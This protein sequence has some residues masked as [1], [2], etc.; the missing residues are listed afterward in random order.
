MSK[1]LTGK[2]NGFFLEKNPHLHMTYGKNNNKKYIEE[3]TYTYK[4]K[5]NPQGA[6]KDDIIKT[7]K[8]TQKQVRGIKTEYNH[9]IVSVKYDG[10]WRSGKLFSIHDDEPSLFDIEE[11]IDNTGQNKHK[12]IDL[13]QKYFKSFSIY[14]IP[15]PVKGGCTKNNHNDCLFYCIKDAIGI[16]NINVK[17]NTPKRLKLKL[18][19]ERDDKIDV[20][21]IPEVEKLMSLNINVSGENNYLS[22]G[23]YQRTVNI[24]LQ[25][26]HY[27]LDITK[28]LKDA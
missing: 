13:S 17:L 18:N 5:K 22:N 28:K 4:N 12:N 14:K 24:I 16:D 11:Y 20:S 21:M 9:F 15:I 7:I 23:D 19:L 2:L 3:I 8:E 6:T 27:T 1:K 26:E 25:D 10:G